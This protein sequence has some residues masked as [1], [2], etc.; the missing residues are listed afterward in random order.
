LERVDDSRR[1]APLE[2]G[3]RE[4]AAFHVACALAENAR[5]REALELADAVLRAAPEPAKL[6]TPEPG[7][8]F[9]LVA[10]HARAAWH[11]G[12]RERAVRLLGNV[13][14]AAPNPGYATWLAAW[15]REVDAVLAAD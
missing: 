13:I 7:S 1:R 8:Y 4:D 12:D 5:A 10:F 11:V 3:R 9:G 15:V 2:P 14:A 6:C